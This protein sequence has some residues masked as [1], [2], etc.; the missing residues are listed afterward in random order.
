MARILIVDSDRQF[1]G[2]IKTYLESLEH[3]CRITAT[4]EEALKSIRDTDVDL[5][6]SNIRLKG[7][8]GLELKRKCE[9]VLGPL[10]FIFMAEYADFK[11][12]EE[13][14][15]E[16]DSA[17]ILMPF[18]MDQLGKVISRVLEKEN[19]KM[20]IANLNLLA[21]LNEFG[22]LLLKKNS[23]EEALALL[24]GYLCQVVN[25]D[26]TIFF[27]EYG[28]NLLEICERKKLC[29]KIKELSVKLAKK[30]VKFY[31]L[32]VEELPDVDLKELDGILEVLIYWVKEKDKVYLTCAA[33]KKSAWFSEKEKVAFNVL[34]DHFSDYY[35]LQRYRFELEKAYFEV[36]EGLAKAIESRDP[37]TGAHTEEV[38]VIA[39]RIAEKLGLSPEER[40][41]LEKASRLHDI[42]KV[43]VPDSIL[44]KPGKLTPEEFEA[45]KKHSV[46]GFE[47]LSKSKSLVEVAKVVLHHHEWYSGGG[48]PDGLKGEEIPLLSRILC[49]AD[50]FHALTSD[51]PY[52]KALSPEK[53]LEIIR[54]ETPLKY[55]PRLVEILEEI[56]REDSIVIR[57]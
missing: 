3:E 25:V 16:G 29:D 53:A 7:I 41:I 34:L 20:E 37:Y 54:K 49:L 45:V 38:A 22:A 6:V 1:A 9:Q 5:V 15:Q 21:R 8:E 56:L 51:R 33:T 28:N 42:G 36:I 47:I 19:L 10:P 27:G 30:D 52:R 2:T 26:E 24:K 46:V 57:N 23:F 50:A 13:V 40:N 14:L 17:L 39:D 55:D 35:L 18:K 4:V 12:I 48:Y 43:A 31:D 32:F 11:M 44:L